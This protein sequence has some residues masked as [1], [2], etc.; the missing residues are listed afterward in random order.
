MIYQ[1]VRRYLKNRYKS[2]STKFEWLDK[3]NQ[4]FLSYLSLRYSNDIVQN[5]VSEIKEAFKD[6]IEPI[7]SVVIRYK[8]GEGVKLKVVPYVIEPKNSKLLRTIVNVILE[9][10]KS[11]EYPY[12][13]R[14][15]QI[16][17]KGKIRR[18]IN[19][20]I[21]Q[22][23][24]LVNKKELIKYAIR[25]AL[26]LSSRDIVIQLKRKF[27]V[28]IFQQNS[29]I[30]PKK[31]TTKAY[32]VT[33]RFNGYL[34]KEVQESYKDIFEKG[35]SDIRFFIKTAVSTLARTTLNFSVIDNSFYELNALKIIHT[36]IAKELENYI[37]LENDFLFGIAG[38]LMR[39]HYVDIHKEL[40]FHLMQSIYQGEQRAKNFLLFYDGSVIVSQEKKYK[41][42]A[43]ISQ[44]NR[45][46]KASIVINMC[47]SWIG[48]KIKK[49]KYELM[50]DDIEI[51]IQNITNSLK[52]IEPRKKE[53]EDI[54]K[55]LVN[56]L[57]SIKK[58][59][60]DLNARVK[61][62]AEIKKDSDEYFDVFQNY[63]EKSKLALKVKDEL[64]KA[65]DD[66]H[67]IKKNHAGAYI[68]IEHLHTKKKETSD[69]IILLQKNIDLK[70][71]QIDPI[72]TT[73]ANA[74]MARTELIS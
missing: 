68:Q 71:T 39:K 60:I 5:E 34:E 3:D 58:E 64:S 67:H 66:L 45:V 42:P 9:N 24:E 56:K 38:Y 35:S 23:D 11:I 7:G 15:D 70:M 13:D 47:N 16:A 4:E 69:A 26:K 32:L 29:T 72:I 49:E 59:L 25:K 22:S 55:T 12:Q 57:S 61:Y 14:N 40:A 31:Q 50:L 20:I 1:Y 63:K 28:K 27:I 17:I 6:F 21:Q 44:D 18:E 65:K 46:W 51:K 10:K 41:L 48:H 53:Q 30:K 36:E 19:Q 33:K 73:I 62:L 52:D 54:I 2:I 74:L 43:L 37:S 8:E